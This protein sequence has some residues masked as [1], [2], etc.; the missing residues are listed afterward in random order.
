MASCGSKVIRDAARPAAEKRFATLDELEGILAG[1][2]LRPRQLNL[3]RRLDR[4][5]TERREGLLYSPVAS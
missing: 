2:T 3:R 1:S 5:G 4:G